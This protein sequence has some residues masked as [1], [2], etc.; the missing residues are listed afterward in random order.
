LTNGAPSRETHN[1][2]W[3]ACDEEEPEV[4]IDTITP[5]SRRSLLTGVLG[6]MAAAATATLAGAQRV[7]A[8]GSDGAPVTIGAGKGGTTCKLLGWGSG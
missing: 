3:R 2:G 1:F 5:R 6:G 7:L 4:A 8:D